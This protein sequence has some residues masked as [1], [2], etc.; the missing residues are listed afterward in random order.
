MSTLADA[1]RA[2]ALSLEALAKIA[3]D[4]G[5]TRRQV[6]LARA[7]KPIGA[8]AHLA[9]C[10]A[11]GI[12]PIDGASRPPKVVSANVV[13]WILSTALY[14]TR[15][16]RK[17]DQ[18]SAARL[19]GV[20]PATVCRVECA[21]PVSVEAMLKVCAFVGVH[22]DGYTAPLDCARRGAT[23]E[24]GTETHCSDLNIRQPEPAHA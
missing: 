12:D 9:L 4:A 7:G 6:C 20:S 16:L 3:G 24:T 21:K 13:W 10:G 14:V 22:P 5:V 18:R 1:L 2:R 8:G 15:N 11:V 17:L 23:R 19:I